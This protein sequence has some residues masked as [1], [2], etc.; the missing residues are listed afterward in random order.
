MKKF[1]LAFVAIV[2]IHLAKAQMPG[3]APAG[4]AKQ[5][6]PSIGRIY[7]KLVDSTGK[8]ID[9]AS[10]VVLKS[11]YDSTT[12]KR[13]DVLLKGTISAANGDFNIEQLPIM[14]P[15]KLT[16]SATGF[17][18][19]TQTVTFQPKMPAG[20]AQTKPAN[21][22]MP[23]MSAMASAFEKDLG[24]VSL[25]KSVKEL[26]EVVVTATKGR[27]KMD[28]DKKVF[29]VD[30]NIVSAGGTAVDPGQPRSGWH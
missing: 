7:G 8:A 14:G 25:V 15:L 19:Y 28:I 5:A 30:Q 9:G 27:L 12:K 3:I 10:V 22:Q 24:K 11:K 20:G 13:K 17:E 23:D 26:S 29:S 21:G 18:A 16:V 1:I 6:P 4:T 2:T